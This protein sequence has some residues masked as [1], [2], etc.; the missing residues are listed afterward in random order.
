VIARVI[1][2]GLLVGSMSDAVLALS[3]DRTIATRAGRF[4][5]LAHSRGRLNRPLTSLDEV[6]S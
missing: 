5:Q 4:P 3:R 1:V 2:V 6:M